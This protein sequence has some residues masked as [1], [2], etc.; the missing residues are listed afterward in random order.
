MNTLSDPF[1]QSLVA[2]LD[3]DN[4]VGVTLAGSYAR[5]D[6]GPYS[7]V[8]IHHY[9]RQMPGDTGETYSLCYA[10]G[11]LVSISLMTVEEELCQPARPTKSQSG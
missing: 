8:D 9:V 11:Y 10:D 7:D 5:G 3:N 6:D 1:F 2:Q 4:T